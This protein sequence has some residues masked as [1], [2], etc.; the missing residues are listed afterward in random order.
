MEMLWFIQESLRNV[1][2][3]KVK[4]KCEDDVKIERKK[5]VAVVD[6]EWRKECFTWKHGTCVFTWQD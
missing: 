4:T 1:E 6:P 2:E 5:Q 3:E